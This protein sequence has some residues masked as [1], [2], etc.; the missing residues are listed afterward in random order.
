MKCKCLCVAVRLVYHSV[1]IYRCIHL[2]ELTVRWCI[3]V[4]DA[5]ISMVISHCNQL[6]ELNL[7]VLEDIT[8]L[9]A[10]CEDPESTLCFITG[11]WCPYSRFITDNKCPPLDHIV[12][13]HNSSHIFITFSLI[14][15]CIACC[16]QIHR[17]IIIISNDMPVTIVFPSV[18]TVYFFIGLPAFLFPCRI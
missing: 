5:G 2:K 7:L 4:T 16:S 6:C 11:L 9:C 15:H 8:G 3:S 1:C 13:R 12:S 14:L 17:I 18:T 10:L